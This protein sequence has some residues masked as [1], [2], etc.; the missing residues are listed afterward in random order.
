MTVCW[1]QRVYVAS[2]R[3]LKR[4]DG[5]TRSPIYSHFGE[6]LQGATTIRAY[7]KQ[8]YFINESERKL[9]VNNQSNYPSLVANR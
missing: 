2:S 7:S 5:V 3:Q 9:D 4:L 1:F 6:S 8:E